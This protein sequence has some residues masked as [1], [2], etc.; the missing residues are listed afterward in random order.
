MEAVRILL[1]ETG[2]ARFD[3]VVHHPHAMPERGDLEFAVK[4]GGTVEGR[5]CIVVTFTVEVH[6]G[7]PPMRAQAVTTLR[8]FLTAA[9]AI[10]AAYPGALHGD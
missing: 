7:L 6:K 4:E 8:N 10:K 5:P 9:E 3:E 1:G 2:A